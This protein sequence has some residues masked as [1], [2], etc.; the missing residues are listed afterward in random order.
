ML[1]DEGHFVVGAKGGDK[2]NNEAS[3]K[4]LVFAVLSWCTPS[5]QRR[6]CPLVVG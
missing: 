1:L 6:A 3:D 2:R 4:E 5:L